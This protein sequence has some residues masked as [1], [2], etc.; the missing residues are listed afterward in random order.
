MQAPKTIAPVQQL[1]S[2]ALSAVLT[3]L[4][5]FSLGA[6]ADTQHA[7]ALASAQGSQQQLC[8][9]PQRTARS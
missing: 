2:M 5:L 4:V 8:V 7:D 6:Q 9:A 3:V 1:A